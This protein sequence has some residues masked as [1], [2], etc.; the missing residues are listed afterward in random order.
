MAWL[1][2]EYSVQFLTKLRVDKHTQIG[3]QMLVLQFL[4]TG[5]S[6]AGIPAY[7]VATV[8]KHFIQ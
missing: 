7:T 4:Q 3:A 8:G 1:F 6:S 5:I 2:L